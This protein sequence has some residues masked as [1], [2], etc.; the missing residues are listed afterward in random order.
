MEEN[1]LP[2]KLR[3]CGRGQR[4][5]WQSVLDEETD[6]GSKHVQELDTVQAVT[7]QAGI[8]ACRG[9]TQGRGLGIPG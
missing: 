3:K 4:F 5:R 2:S 8:P 7:H 1:D 6:L 9:L